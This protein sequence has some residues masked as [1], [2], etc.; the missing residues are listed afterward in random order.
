MWHR[1]LIHT[2]AY[3][4]GSYASS[5][6]DFI[7]IW[8]KLQCNLSVD[9][10]VQCMK[11]V[12]I[13]NVSKCFNISVGRHGHMCPPELK[14][15][16]KLSSMPNVNNTSQHTCLES[17]SKFPQDMPNVN[18]T[19]QHTCPESSSKFLQDM[20]NVN[21]TCQHTCPE[22]SSKFPQDMP[23]VNITGQHTCSECSSKFLQDMPTV[24]ITGQHTCSESSSKFP[25]DMPNVNITVVQRAARSF[26]K[27]CLT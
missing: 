4:C 24:N 2:R 25:K 8:N 23:N 1:G 20:P 5:Y 7:F 22:S 14:R 16:P 3:S 10:S 21:I 11:A 26:P 15:Q 13:I 18:N 27:T 12:V 6:F 19:S 9:V 17:S